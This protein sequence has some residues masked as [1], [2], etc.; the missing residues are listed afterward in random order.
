M[1]KIIALLMAM[2][3]VLSLAACGAKEEP[4][5]PAATEAPAAAVEMTAAEKAAAEAEIRYALG[6]LLDRNYIV[7]EITQAGQVPASSFVPMGM[8][9]PD[10][11]QFYKTANSTTDSFDGYYDVSEDALDEKIKTLVFTDEY[12]AMKK[13]AESSATDVYLYSKIAEKS[14]ECFHK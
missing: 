2:A 8:M 6:L 11:T 9:N 3:M 7:E 14:L 12:N 4:A 1:K 10:G 13:V 5:A